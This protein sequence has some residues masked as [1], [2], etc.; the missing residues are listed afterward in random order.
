MSA[1]PDRSVALGFSGVNRGKD[2]PTLFEIEVG[3]TSIGADIS[4]LSQFEEEREYCLP[5]LTHLQVVGTPR[6]EDHQGQQLS[7]LRMRLTVNQRSKTVEQAEAARGRGE[8]DAAATLFEKAIDARGRGL[9]ADD[10]Q[11]RDRIVAMRRVLMEVRGGGRE[12]WEQARAK[13]GLASD[14]NDQ[15]AFEEALALYQ[16]ALELFT[17]VRFQYATSMCACA[18]IALHRGLIFHDLYVSRATG[19][20]LPVAY[21]LFLLL[22]SLFAARCLFF[23]FTTGGRPR[24]PGRGQDS[25]EHGYHL[26]GPG[27]LRP[28]P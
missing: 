15:N 22:G 14:L 17:E 20:S 24:L 8:A 27:P 10:K 26:P 19:F 12:K 9:C 18:C 3:K 6:L 16:E 11:G 13:Y 5:P 7:I 25:R 23:V 28:S 4:W 1:T 21:I 2:L